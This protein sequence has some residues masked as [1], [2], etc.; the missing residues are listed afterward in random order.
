[1]KAGE[2]GK[3]ALGKSFGDIHMSASPDKQS[4]SKRPGDKQFLKRRTVEEG[5]KLADDAHTAT[6]RLYCEVFRFWRSCPVKRC[7]RERRCMGEP[8]RC[9][10]RGLPGVPPAQRVA[11]EKDVAAGGPRR[12]APA[13]HMEW[14]ARRQPLPVLTTWRGTAGEKQ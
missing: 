2:D 8:A 14:V 12:V 3:R 10:M 7:K 4:P 13:T 5:L 9:L 6:W 11:A 1:V